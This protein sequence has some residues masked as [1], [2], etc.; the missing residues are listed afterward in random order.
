MQTYFGLDS[1]EEPLAQTLLETQ[2]GK[3][4]ICCTLTDML[5]IVVHK[6][7]RQ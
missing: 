6:V 4:G 1:G 2:D 5:T 7:N 3:L